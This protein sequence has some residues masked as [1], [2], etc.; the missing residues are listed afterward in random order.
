LIHFYKRCVSL[1]TQLYATGISKINGQNVAIST[2][3]DSG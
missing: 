3:E 1:K 2:V